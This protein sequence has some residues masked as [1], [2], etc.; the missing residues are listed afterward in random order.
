MSEKTRIEWT[1]G[2]W[3]PLRGCSPES[4]G[5]RH[6]YAMGVAGRFSGPGMP[7]EGLTIK[8][9][10]GYK[11]NGKIKL[12][13][14]K[15]FEPLRKKRPRRIFVNSMS[16]LFHAGVPE[17]FIDRV[18]AVMALSPQHTYQVLTKQPK[19]MR[20]Y[21]KAFS[22]ARVIKNCTGEDGASVIPGFTLQALLHHFGQVPESTL[23]S[24]ALRNAYPLP[25]VWLGVSAENQVKADE[26]IPILLDTPAAVHWLSLEPLLGRVNLH[27]HLW[28]DMNG[29]V[30]SQIGRSPRI[31]WVVVGGESGPEAR[32][33]HPDWVKNLHDQCKAADIRFLFKQWGEWKPISHMDESEWDRYYCSNRAAKEGENQDTLDEIY[34]RT[35]RIPTTSIGY[36][37]A[38]GHEAFRSVDGH[39]GMQMFKVGKKASG[40]LLDGVLHDEYP[41][42]RT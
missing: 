27:A 39:G 28:Q 30:V 25:N 40:R 36:G 19:R 37:G 17:W 14:Q 34:G 38:I 2:T 10:Q 7:Y 26:R 32:P 8:T 11:W 12:V 9:T 15:L 31:D 41:E 16:D 20:D 5:C 33:M 13:P 4:D 35:C 6:C 22:W 42:A 21:C 29:N 3:N 24:F 18:F 1:D 23:T